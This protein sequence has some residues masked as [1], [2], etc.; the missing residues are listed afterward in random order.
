[1]TFSEEKMNLSLFL[2]HRAD[3]FPMPNDLAVR[4]FRVQSSA[5]G[6]FVKE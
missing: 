3:A 1:M 2:S 4:S 6:L 5:P